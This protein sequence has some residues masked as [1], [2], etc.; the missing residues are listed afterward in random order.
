[1]PIAKVQLQDGRI[2]RFE[3]PEGTT[4]QEVE[5]FA[6]SQF[7]ADGPATP[8][9]EA[10]KADPLAANTQE[11]SVPEDIKNA[12]LEFISGVNRGVLSIADAPAEIANAVLQL[13]GAESR[14][15]LLREQELLQSGSVG[16][17]LP[18][19]IPRQVFATAG[20]FAAPGLP[21]KAAQGSQVLDDVATALAS[22]SGVKQKIGQ[23]ILEGSTDS[24]VAKFIRDGAGRVSKDKAAIEAINQGFD[25]AV[26]SAVK[27]ASKADRRKMLEMSKIMQKS[28]TDRVFSTRNRPTDIVGK[29]LLQRVRHIKAAN[30]EAG[31]AVAKAAKSLKGKSVDFSDAV[32]GFAN[33]LDDIG[34]R[35]IDDGK[36]GVKPLFQG[37][38]IEGVDG[39]ERAIKKIVSR[40]SSDKAP[41]AFDVHRMKKFIDEQVT[42]G[43]S[44]EG[45]GGKA[46][47]VLK[48]LRSGL[49]GALDSTF[50]AYDKANSK[51]SETIG[52][53]DSLQDA[54]GKKFD[55]FGP[56]SDKA[57]GTILRR[58]LSNAKSRV[59][60]MDSMDEIE[61]VARSTG[62]KFDDDIMTQ[63]LFA[64]E[65]NNKF[66]TT[67][68][69]SL[70]GA[71]QRGVTQAGRA[72]D[73]GVVSAGIE[74]AEKLTKRAI[75]INNENA[76]KAINNVLSR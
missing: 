3:V 33:D 44:V 14:V 36:G 57:I 63:V 9:A 75:G 49:D 23:K 68:R 24:S 20:E 26:I 45:L 51:F 8:Q 69:T 56:S 58:T 71:V 66:G 42:F 43:K 21:I 38:D 34:V 19:G 59:D 12:A 15:P 39:A 50:P 72:I 76:F 65:L 28:I 73:R 17:F 31:K 30:R 4:P 64:E 7:Q 40:M 2:A 29:S 16:G 6:S 37:S 70:E 46:E 10:T 32:G 35:I 1:M 18:E 13:S 11:T 67:A 27:G 48:D 47:R 52:A 54:A 25:D 22:Q 41:D 5:S 74:G 62:G 55:L 53:I 60:L 61:R